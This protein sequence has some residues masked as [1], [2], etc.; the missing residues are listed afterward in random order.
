MIFWKILENV[1]EGTKRIH[2]LIEKIKID[3]PYN[4]LIHFKSN[5]H[6]E[7][8]DKQKQNINFN[9]GYLFSWSRK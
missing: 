7:L 5:L 4:I 2:H 3:N 8:V 1:M 6:Y 9:S